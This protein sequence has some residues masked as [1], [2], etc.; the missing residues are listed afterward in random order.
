MLKKISLILIIVS[1]MTVVVSQIISLT[2]NSILGSKMLG[3][4]LIAFGIGTIVY[5]VYSLKSGSNKSK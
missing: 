3:G 5:S 2:G 4:A 1:S